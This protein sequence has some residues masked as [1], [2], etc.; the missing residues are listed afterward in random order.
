MN[1]TY[2][3]II[4]TYK[5]LLPIFWPSSLNLKKKF[6]ASCVFNIF[7]IASTSLSPIFFKYVIDS[8]ENTRDYKIIFSFLLGY[9][10]LWVLGKIFASL[11][12]IYLFPLMEKA[13]SVLSFKIYQQ[14]HR[15]PYSY[16][17]NKKT[18][19]ITGFID[20]ALNYFPQIIW[21]LIFRFIPL[22]LEAL[23]AIGALAYFCGINYALILT[24]TVFFLGVVSYRGLYEV[25]K[26]F[27]KANNVHL[28]VFSQMVDGILNFMNIR[29]FMTHKSDQRRVSEIL[30]KKYDINCKA[31]VRAETFRLYQI[32]IL[33]LSFLFLFLLTGYRVT[34]GTL[35]L[36]DFAMIHGY[37]LHFAIPIE[38]FTEMFRII[39]I[40]LTKIRGVIDILNK[41]GPRKRG[42]IKIKKDALLHVVFKKVTFGY[43]KNKPFLKKISF[44]IK[45][46]ETVVIVGSTGEGKST[47]INL[48][49]GFYNVWE[50]EIII[51]GYPIDDIDQK[52]LMKNIG[53]VPQSVS[54]FNNSIK[55]NLAFVKNS[56]VKE[57]DIKKSINF[58]ELEGTLQTLPK[59]I[60][61]QVGEQG[62][63][64]SG[65]EKQRLGLARAFLVKPKLYLLDEATSA[66]DYQTEARIIQHIKD[67]KNKGISC[68]II[69]HRKTL[70]S[71]ADRIY[72]LKHGTLMKYKKGEQSKP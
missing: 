56:I 10:V 53:V 34:I 27:E 30:E 12:E 70:Y 1:T 19:E 32:L 3:S 11:R 5:V 41:E 64:L 38:D 47:I 33:S 31:C 51:N 49:L 67:Q 43:E 4:D 16:H 50:G 26:R 66:L 8:F 58:A 39:N 40:G 23:I 25:I 6:Y 57:I 7:A 18:G 69:T 29:Y 55:N 71:L 46:G 62:V 28:K 63:K 15:L 36:G 54:L 61:T 68:L 13:I 20:M 22:I 21:P 37:L 2:K 59:G 48:L 44:E 60:Y 45:P 17:L 72:E 52:S 65:G 9:V 14:L 42:Y 24:L 35:S